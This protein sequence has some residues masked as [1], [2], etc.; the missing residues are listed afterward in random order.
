ML[1][2]GVRFRSDD[3]E[4]SPYP[5]FSAP[6]QPSAM[7]TS[8]I[9]W[10]VVLAEPLERL[11]QAFDGSHRGDHGYSKVHFAAQTHAVPQ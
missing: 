5:A 9:S 2:F 8:G 10:V 1:G 7:T 4:L 6:T 3:R 11:W